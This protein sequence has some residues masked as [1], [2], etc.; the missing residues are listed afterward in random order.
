MRLRIGMK[1][2]QVALALGL[3]FIAIQPAH[4]VLEGTMRDRM[5]ML[6]F[7]E[8]LIKQGLYP[9]TTHDV[10]SKSKRAFVHGVKQHNNP[11]IYEPDVYTWEL[12]MAEHRK[13][14][15]IKYPAPVPFVPTMAPVPMAPPPILPSSP[16]AVQLTPT[17]SYNVT[18]FPVALPPNSAIR[19]NNMVYRARLRGI[20]PNDQLRGAQ[21]KQ[22][23]IDHMNSLD[24][25]G[26]IPAL[27]PAM[28][29]GRSGDSYDSNY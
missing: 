14:L 19:M 8:G 10:F 3:G 17:G 6:D 11:R 27:M 21:I 20:Y 5:E 1:L 25:R 26:G 24:N 18:E 28:P 12:A 7:S 29:R 9:K 15:A 22:R 16:M 2:T 23:L 13:K 4:A